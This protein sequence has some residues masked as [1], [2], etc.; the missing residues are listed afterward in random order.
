MSRLRIGTRASALARWQANAVVRALRERHPAVATELVELTT[1]GDDRPDAPLE[2]MEGT[3]WFT[4]TLEGALIEGRIDVAVHSY[5]DLPV[6]SGPELTV[7]ATLE[8]GPVEDV[9]CAARRTRLEAL[10]SGARVGTSSLRRLAQLRLIRPDLT[11]LPLRGN[12]PTRLERIA[13]GELDAV[14]LARAGLERLGL[15]SHAAEVFPIARLLPAPGQGALAI[16]TRREDRETTGLAAALDHAPTH[17]AVRAERAVLRA[18]RGGCSV[19]VG[20]VARPI[21]GG[22]WLRAGVFGIEIEEAITIRVQGGD[23]LALADEAA[24]RLIERG[25]LRLLERTA[26]PALHRE[27]LP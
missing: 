15:M 26:D 9:L 27:T 25:A 16:Q 14:V 24:A 4:S 7:A 19:P 12:V 23:P 8:R 10:E 18:L 2:R 13:R 20:V 11:Y 6:E 22:F 5:K 21:G 3:G 17:D 1:A